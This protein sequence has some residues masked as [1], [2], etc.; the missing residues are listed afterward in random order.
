MPK[1]TPKRRG[2]GLRR[3]D[4]REVR[5]ARETMLAHFKTGALA[6]FDT[7]SKL[8]R[9]FGTQLRFAQAFNSLRMAAI[10]AIKFTADAL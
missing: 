5:L 9:A 10:N 3:I 1:P 8:V 4:K 2:R 7:H 6:R